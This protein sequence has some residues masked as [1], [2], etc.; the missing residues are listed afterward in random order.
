MSAARPLTGRKVLAIALAAFG[1]VIA[2]N[3]VMIFAATGTFPG[4]VVENSYVASQQWQAET[5]AQK[6]LGWTVEIAHDADRLAIVPRG[7]DGTIVAGLEFRATVGRPSE[8]RDDIVV[9]LR[10]TGEGYFAPLD[11]APGLWRAELHTVQGPAYR[12]STVFAVP[13]PE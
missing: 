12:I 3:L 1:T 13:D 7:K 6:A 10:G 2:A 8:D 11:L 4:L 9:E 5:D